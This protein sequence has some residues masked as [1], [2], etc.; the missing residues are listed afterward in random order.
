MDTGAG[1][2]LPLLCLRGQVLRLHLKKPAPRF[3]SVWLEGQ[4]QCSVI[5]GFM[6]VRRINAYY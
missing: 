3:T 2:N 4:T 5:Q 6:R 1:Q